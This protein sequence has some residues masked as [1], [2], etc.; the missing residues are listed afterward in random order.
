MGMMLYS[1]DMY[2]TDGPG[3]VHID[4]GA[5]SIGLA[6]IKVYNWPLKDTSDFLAPKPG[7]EDG[8]TL[9]YSPAVSDEGNGYVLSYDTS[10]LYFPKPYAVMLSRILEANYGTAFVS[11]PEVQQSWIIVTA[12][13]ESICLDPPPEVVQV[14]NP[15]E[16]CGNTPPE[17]C[18]T[19]Q[20]VLDL[21]DDTFACTPENDITYVD[22]DFY[23]AKC[24]GRRKLR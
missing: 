16:S 5:E 21:Y 11:Y 24:G 23:Q 4:I 18:Y 17:V 14:Y 13:D 1:I 9:E 22:I 3:V 20:T 15:P 19:G 6:D 2:Q 12:G 8:E 7:F 10:A